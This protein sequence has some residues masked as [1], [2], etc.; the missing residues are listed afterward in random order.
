MN[1]GIADATN[2]AWLLSAA[3]NGWAHPDILN[4]YEAERHP[5]TEQVSHFVMNHAQKMI[6][7]RR[8]VPHNIEDL[9][10][11]GEAARHLIGAEAYDLNVQQFCCEGLNFGYFYEK[12]PII[13]H[14]SEAAPDYSMGAFTPSTLPGCRAPHFWLNDGT[15]LYDLLGNGYSLL[16]FDQS[17]DVHALL[18]NTSAENIPFKLIDLHTQE[19]KPSAYQHPLVLC[20]TDQHVVWRGHELPRSVPQFVSFLKGFAASAS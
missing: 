9:D 19:Q 16:R 7:A 14:E 13:S 20:R 10:A 5:I 17:I 4:A 11:E 12:S 18:Q 3:V 6:K 1:A 15:S 8:A 2:L